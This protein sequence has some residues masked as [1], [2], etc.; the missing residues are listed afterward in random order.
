[1]ERYVNNNVI[2]YHYNEIKKVGTYMVKRC[3]FCGH[4]PSY[5]VKIVDSIITFKLCCD[6]IYCW[7]KP[8]TIYTH[9][10]RTAVNVWNTRKRGYNNAND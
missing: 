10:Y 7:V 1:M 3:P 8:S 9:N 2:I 6:N 5:E 4:N